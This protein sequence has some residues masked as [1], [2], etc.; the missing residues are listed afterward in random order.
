MNANPFTPAQREA[1]AKLVGISPETH[2]WLFKTGHNFER[3]ETVYTFT[4]PCPLTGGDE[5]DDVWGMPL[6]RFLGLRVMSLFP[7]GYSI[8]DG[9]GL[10]GWTTTV[11][12]T[13]DGTTTAAPRG[14]V[15]ITPALLLAARAA[16]I[17]EV[18]A[19]FDMGEADH[20]VPP[21]LAE[22]QKK[23]LVELSKHDC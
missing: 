1:L 11:N 22:G 6:L 21:V 17:P 4:G 20:L 10:A 7:I 13:T 3:H 19:I 8:D 9:G 14:A 18:V 16:G 23:R 15:T 5:A 12:S 2:R